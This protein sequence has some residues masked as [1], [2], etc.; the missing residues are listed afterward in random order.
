MS[1]I[2]QEEILDRIREEQP[3][4]EAEFYDDYN[5]SEFYDV[6]SDL[7][8]E[9]KVEQLRGKLKISKDPFDI[10]AKADLEDSA[11]ND[12]EVEF[13]SKYGNPG[14]V[15]ILKNILPSYEIETACTGG[16]QGTY[17][18]RL[19]GPEYIWLIRDSYGSCSYCDGLIDNPDPYNYGIQMLRNGYAFESEDDAVQFLKL[20][21][22]FRWERVKGIALELF[23][24]E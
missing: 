15:D 3:I 5:V 14:R 10:Q 7:V 6:L 17:V 13:E 12:H 19:D 11:L 4:D 22:N 8:E 9:D 2:T 1:D 23:D 20:V 21:G 18:F 16:Y 24:E